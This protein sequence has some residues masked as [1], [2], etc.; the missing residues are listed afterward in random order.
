LESRLLDVSRDEFAANY[1]ARDALLTRAAS[2]FSDV[3]SSGAADE[4]LSCRGL[5]TPFLR[6]AKDGTTLPE[7]SFTAP[8]GVGATVADQVDDTALWRQFADGATMVLQ[9]VHRTWA[10]VAELASQLGTELG[11][12]VQANAYITPP[13]N[14]GF[15]DHYDVHDVFVLQIEG[16]KRWI[17]HRP[18][19]PDPLR[20]QPWT[21][22][23]EAIEEAARGEP[24]LDTV[25]QAGDCLYLPRGWIH[26]A[27]AMGDVSIHLTLG[28]HVWTRYAIAEQLVHDALARLRDQPGLRSTLPM[29]VTEPED[30]DIEQIRDQLTQAVSQADVAPAFRRARNTQARPAPLGPLA[31]L[32]ALEKL[33]PDDP[34][35]FRSALNP[36]LEDNRL[37]TRVGW[38]DLEPHDTPIV[39]PLLAGRVHHVGDLGLDLARRLM[40]AGILL[41]A[42]S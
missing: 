5:R 3:F 42:Q 33:T 38:I 14:Q 21:D 9:A 16:S 31:Q 2:D 11:H 17:I 20:D 1:W 22:H 7:A 35:A 26:A 8:A 30:T 13:Q 37:H 15:D 40:R 23:R 29:G 27:K 28:V 32:A 19:Y 6:V 10:P 36:R 24:V 41:P 39:R 25:L 18:V 4:L 12:P 34:V